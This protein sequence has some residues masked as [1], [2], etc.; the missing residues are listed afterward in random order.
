MAE[1]FPNLEKKTKTKN[2]HPIQ[3]VHKG[4]PKMN[5]IRPT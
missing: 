3:E 2:R 5:P 4:P 1:N